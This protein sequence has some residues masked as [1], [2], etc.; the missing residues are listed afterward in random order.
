MSEQC[1]A[2]TYHILLD[3]FTALVF[4]R[5]HQTRCYEIPSLSQNGNN[6]FKL[7]STG[8]KQKAGVFTVVRN[9]KNISRF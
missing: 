4:G 1:L 7:Q 6:P 2:N 9:S 5:Y 3:E 8:R